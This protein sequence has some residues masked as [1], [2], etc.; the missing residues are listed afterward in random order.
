MS[1]KN[2]AVE[3]CT[4][5]LQ[6][7]TGTI[8]INPGQTSIKVKCSGKAVYT[9][10]KFTVSGYTGGAITVAESGAGSGEIVATAKKTLVESK[11]VFL[12]G[13]K[14]TVITLNGLQPSG[15][16]TA[17]ATATDTVIIQNAGQSKVKGA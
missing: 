9:A 3:G 4:L 13:D 5:Q 7:G 8:T 14:S 16:E 11:A 15:S 17:P 12:E 1:L 10:L 2:I 6:S